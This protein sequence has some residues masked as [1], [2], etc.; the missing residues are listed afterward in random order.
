[1]KYDKTKKYAQSARNWASK[2]S[3]YKFTKENMQVSFVNRVVYFRHGCSVTQKT[4]TSP[5]IKTL[6]PLPRMYS[7]HSYILV[8]VL[9]NIIF[10][11]LWI[12]ICKFYKYKKMWGK[13]AE[14]WPSKIS[15]YKF[16][17][18]KFEISF[19]N[20]CRHFRPRC[21]VTQ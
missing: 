20:R 8:V 13:N 4:Y 14:F 1:M 6:A 7:F 2:I 5:H 21:E 16:K 9:N 19:I 15:F 12:F 18:E 10:S 17:K 3:F 11:F